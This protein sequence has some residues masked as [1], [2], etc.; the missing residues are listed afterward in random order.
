MVQELAN[1]DREQF[2]SYIFPKELHDKWNLLLI[3]IVDN[4]LTSNLF[5]YCLDI[6]LKKQE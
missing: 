5:T 6:R 1:D 3:I 2:D 4:N